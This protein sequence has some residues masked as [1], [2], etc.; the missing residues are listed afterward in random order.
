MIYPTPLA[1]ALAAA[2]APLALLLGALVPAAWPLGLFWIVALAALILADAVLGANRRALEL[3]LQ[4]PS[5]AYVGKSLPASVELLF[6]KGPAPAYVDVRLE[7]NDL[8]KPAFRFWRS[9]SAANRVSV[10]TDSSLP[11][12]GE[13]LISRIWIEWRGP[14]RLVT[15]RRI[16]TVERRI[17]IV[18]DIGSV[19]REALR[20]FANDASIGSRE[21][22]ERGGG[23][24]FEALREF[25]PGMDRRTIDWKQSARHTKLLAKEFR[26]EQDQTIIFAIDTGRLMC[27]PIGPMPKIDHAIGAAMLLTY[28]SLKMGDRVGLF[29]FDAR[30]RITSAPIAGV[31]AFGRIQR[32]AAKLD[33]ST[34]ETNFTLG[35]SQLAAENQRRSLIVIFTDFVDPTS[36]ELMIENIGRLVRKHLVLFVTMRDQEL[37]DLTTIEPVRVLDAT[38]SVIA[39]TLLMERE[40]VLSRLQRLGVVLIDAPVSRLGPDLLNRYL[41]LKRASRL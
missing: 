22:F 4:A 37:E 16:M 29:G 8:L 12:R 25:L 32:L 2:G 24:E 36:A 39:H 5:V 14:L 17:D 3:D 7:T 30:P 10:A 19:K 1:I 34:E 31:S 21:Y 26:T 27:E 28:V 41:E 33:Y 13:G 6:R 9:R 38:R 20:I 11:R 35:L 23:S 15:K 40:V 18:P